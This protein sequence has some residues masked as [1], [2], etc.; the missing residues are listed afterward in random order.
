M[1]VSRHRIGLFSGTIILLGLLAYGAY[2]Y[3]LV[4]PATPIDAVPDNAGMV[5]VTGKPLKIWQKLKEDNDVWSSLSKNPEFG[6]LHRAITTIDSALRRH[7]NPDDFFAERNIVVSLHHLEGGKKDF[8][9]VSETTPVV[10][11]LIMLQLLGNK[12]GKGLE[13][14][15]E[16]KKFR[17]IRIAKPEQS[18]SPLYYTFR[19]GLFLA[20]YSPD[21]LGMAIEKL[22]TKASGSPMNDKKAALNV[23]GKT[24]DAILL[25]NFNQLPDGAGFS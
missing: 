13:M 10:E 20:S 5:L 25:V 14:P 3:V 23:A 22:Y 4:T 1:K 15:K 21:L 7:I 12:S 16:L 11:N 6:H 24:N 8:L 18:G 2:N 9:F 17:K 19:Q